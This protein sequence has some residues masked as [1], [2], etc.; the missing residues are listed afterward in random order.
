MVASS[1]ARTWV[2][3]GALVVSIAALL[4]CGGDDVIDVVSRDAAVDGELLDGSVADGDGGSSVDADL[5][6]DPGAD[7]DAD[8]VVDAGADL[9]ADLVVDAG[10]DLDAAIGSS[11]GGGLDDGGADGGSAADGGAGGGDG[12][13]DGGSD[14]G[15]DAG[16]DA[17]VD[18]GFDAGVD[19]GVDAGFDAG[20]V[21]GD[22]I[23]G[24][25]GTHAVRF[26]W[27]GSGS[28]STAYVMYERNQLPD[29]SR[30]RVRALSSNIGYTP[31]FTDVF[32]GEGGLDLGGTVFIDV[33]LSTLG[34]GAVRNATIAVYGRSF[35]TTSSGS[36]TWQTFSGTG[37]SPS[38][39]VANSAPYQW[40]R[41]NATAAL[42]GGN[43]S[44]LL[45]LRAG[46]P[47]SRLVVNRV[48]ICF[49]A[50]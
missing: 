47:S 11:D 9:D 13:A 14:G 23:S 4:A 10:A 46:P 6:A 27:G 29:T 1:E 3:R 32:L 28:G 48:E 2:C 39:S 5:G 20:V 44:T 21:V 40:Y 8:L 50:E 18:A 25:S 12:G 41:A 7:L 33:E 30:W 45:R 26:R 36:F 31:V 49:D 43:G 38:G 19:A 17:G 24:A 34:L 42:P 16:V 22:C 35:H 37:A 15:F